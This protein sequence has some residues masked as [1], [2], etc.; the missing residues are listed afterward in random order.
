MG[1]R[2]VQRQLPGKLEAVDRDQARRWGSRR[3]RE[4]KEAGPSRRSDGCLKAKPRPDGRQEEAGGRDQVRRTG[5]SG[6]K[7]A[8]PV[9]PASG[10]RLSASANLNRCCGLQ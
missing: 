8:T 10:S 1:S 3:R 7:I 5:R 9:T 6:G 2:E 4:A